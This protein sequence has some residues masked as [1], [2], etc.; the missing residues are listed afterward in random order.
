MLVLGRYVVGE[1]VL[2]AVILPVVMSGAVGAGIPVRSVAWMS[3]LPSSLAI[4]NRS[5]FVRGNMHS[6]HLPV[7]C[8]LRLLRSLYRSGQIQPVVGLHVVL[9]NP[10]AH[11]VERAHRTLRGH[12]SLFRG[13][14]VP[15]RSLRHIARK[16]LA[17]IA[18]ERCQVELSANV[19]LVCRFLVPLRRQL[20]IPRHARPRRIALANRYLRR[21]VPC[22]RLRKQNRIDTR[23][24][25]NPLL[26]ARHLP[27]HKHHSSNHRY[28]DKCN[29]LR[30]QRFLDHL[31][32]TIADSA[33]PETHSSAAPRAIRACI[34]PHSPTPPSTPASDQ[35]KPRAAPE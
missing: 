19:A 15:R 4:L 14:L 17:P 10:L 1:A 18:I 31:S 16:S 26:R 35:S 32:E 9:L 33:A 28:C 6:D 21:R 20:V 7:G 11:R 25:R 8:V 5:Q 30:S 2:D 12:V 3:S 22:I 23:L 27:R 13:L 29:Q 24:L 34:L